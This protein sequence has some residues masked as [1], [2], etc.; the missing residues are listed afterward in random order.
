[1]TDQ[2]A[3]QMLLPSCSNCPAARKLA[4]RPAQAILTKGLSPLI[5]TMNPP[6]LT[7]VLT[8][9]RAP[10]T[11]EMHVQSAFPGVSPEEVCFQHPVLKARYMAETSLMAREVE[12]IHQQVNLQA[13]GLEQ[14]KDTTNG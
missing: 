1:M 13:A 9:G 7:H 12:T 8:P 3:S 11:M 2:P 5:C 4:N 10:N 14:Q 6:Q